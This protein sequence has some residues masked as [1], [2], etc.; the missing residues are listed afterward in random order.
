MSK[1]TVPMVGPKLTKS[2]SAMIS[3]AKKALVATGDPTNIIVA[4]NLRG[5]L[6][7]IN[8]LFESQRKIEKVAPKG[9]KVEP[10]TIEPTT[11][12]ATGACVAA[13]WLIVCMMERLQDGGLTVIKKNGKRVVYGARPKQ[14]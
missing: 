9:F 11:L 4:K 14:N 5:G 2:Q 12:K 3:K 8:Y 10:I 13:Q 6:Q 1:L 7:V